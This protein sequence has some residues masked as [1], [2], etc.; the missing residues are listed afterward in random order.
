MAVHAGFPVELNGLF[1]V[2]EVFQRR[3]SA[4]KDGIVK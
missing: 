1:A 3:D 2:K 4:A